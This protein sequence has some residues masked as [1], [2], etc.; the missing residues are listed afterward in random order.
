MQ[1]MASAIHLLS[2]M[3]NGLQQSVNKFRIDDLA[4]AG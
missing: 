1:Q 3:T 4:V 2:D